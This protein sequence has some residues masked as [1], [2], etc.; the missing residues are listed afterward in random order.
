[1]TKYRFA[2]YLFAAI[3][4]GCTSAPD[5]PVEGASLPAC[6]VFPNCVSSETIEGADAVAPLHASVQQWL[7]LKQWLAAQQDWTIIT[8]TENFLQAVVQTPVMRFRDDV[9]LRFVDATGV[10]HVRSSSRLGIGDMGA[11]LKR[12][13]ILRKQLKGDT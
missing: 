6:G 13:D 10:I 1:M 9:Q 7:A 5:K 11:N 4:V 2:L 3:L 12:V 8:D